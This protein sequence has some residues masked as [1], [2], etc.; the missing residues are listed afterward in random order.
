MKWENLASLCRSKA[1]CD[2]CRLDAGKRLLMQGIRE[3]FDCETLKTDPSKKA[4]FTV[5]VRKKGCVTCGPKTF[6]YTDNAN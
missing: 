6:T 1:N 3:P 5:V 4:T 2:K